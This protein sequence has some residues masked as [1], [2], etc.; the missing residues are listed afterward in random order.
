M[1]QAQVKGA[2]TAKEL[3]RRFEAGGFYLALE[4]AQLQFVR[5]I[6]QRLART[7]LPVEPGE[8]LELA[9]AVGADRDWAASFI[10][11]SSERGDE[12]EIRGLFTLSLNEHPH[13]LAVYGNTLYAWCAQDTLFLVPALGQPAVISSRDPQSGRPITLTS[14]DGSQ[15]SNVDPPSAIVSMAASSGAQPRDVFE[16]WSM[17]CEHMHFFE[18]EE[19]AR[20]FLSRREGEF[21]WLTVDEALAFGDG[22]FNPESPL[23]RATAE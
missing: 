20:A 11:W 9:D 8:A 12:G 7:A 13:Q 22:F 6:W 14:D 16:I 18:S 23:R 17:F 4:S 3:W 19:T 2:T 21:Y 5:S 1:T 15:I 10:E